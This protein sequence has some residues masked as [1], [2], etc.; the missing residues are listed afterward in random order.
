ARRREPPRWPLKRLEPMSSPRA[1]MGTTMY[2]RTPEASRASDSGLGG[3]DLHVDHLGLAPPQGRQVTGE[4]QRIANARALVEAT[5]SDGGEPFHRARLQIEQVD[6]GARDA[7]QI[8]T[9][10]EGG[11][12]DRHRRFRGDQSEIDLVQEV[13][14]C[15]GGGQRARG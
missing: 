11:R 4:L 5:A 15:V 12:G 14:P 1:I 8:A 10:R 6:G 13:E 9:S 7:E 2:T 3:S